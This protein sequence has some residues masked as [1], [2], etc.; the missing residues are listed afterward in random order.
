MKGRRKRQRK[1]TSHVEIR[2]AGAAAENGT[3]TAAAAVASEMTAAAAGS[4][5]IA[6]AAS[7]TKK[8]VERR[9]TIKV[10]NPVARSTMM[11]VEVG[12]GN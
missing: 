9:M 2:A 12:K 4:G 7:E 11:K 8:A 1:A 10:A 6:V 3:R 5:M